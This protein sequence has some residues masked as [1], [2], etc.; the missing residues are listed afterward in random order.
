MTIARKLWLGFGALI[1]LFAVACLVIFLSQ[2]SIDMALDNIVRVE[3]PTRA[4][5]FEMEINT[6]EI[7]RDVL[8][9]LETGEPRYREQFADDRADFERFKARYDG[10]VE[11]RENRELGDRIDSLYEEYVSLG[12]DLM[13]ERDG[14]ASDVDGP[15]EEDV[16]E[17][18]A[19]QSDLDDVLD[20]EVQPRTEDQLV[21]GERR[22]EDAILAVYTTIGLLLVF[23]LVIGTLA[24]YLINRGIIDSVSRLKEGAQRVGEG[25]LDHRIDLNTTDELG[26]VAGALNS[27]LD[28]RREA[29][30]ALAESEGRFRGLSD[31]TF[32]GIVIS[33][34]EKVLQVNRAFT[35]MFGY[36]SMEVPGMSTLDFTLP[37]YH[38]LTREHMRSGDE[39]PYEAV[40]LRKDGSTLDIELRGRASTYQGHTAY[41]TT[42]RDVTERKRAEEALRQSEARTRAI[43]ETTPD[44][45]ITMTTD[46]I[47]HSFNR[48]AERIFGYEAAQVV[49]E[50]LRNLMPERFKG[51]HEEGF[52]RYLRT[53]E[54]HVV[55]KGPAELVGLRAD[56][57]EFPL[58]LSLWARCAKRGTSCSRAS[59]GTSPVARG[60]RRPSGRASSVSEPSPRT[61]RLSPSPWTGTACLPSRRAGALSPWVSGRTTS[62]A[63]PCSSFTGRC[64]R[65]GRTRSAPSPASR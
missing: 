59:C 36:G 23:G 30:G 54:A 20:E 47:V 53:G 3:E 62:S 6:V 65:F 58:E 4:A 48:G 38:D 60:P 40:G 63:A 19:L 21:E 55:D 37:E 8:D 29:E 5:S 11:T 43:V 12:G 16:R 61:P 14:Q 7:S 26:V 52:L 9:Y 45:I 33:D 56:G 44:G 28:R 27:M 17:F 18:L 2:R 22:A 46:G 24:A 49:G 32:E 57:T 42:I 50:P 13:D 51:P 25:D 1:L 31:A 34:D 15:L 39:N 64:R 10:L 35:R 41:V